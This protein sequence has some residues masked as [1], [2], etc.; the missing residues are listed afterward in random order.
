MNG[1]ALLPMIWK[2][3]TRQQ[4]DLPADILTHAPELFSILDHL[5]EHVVYLDCDLRV[6][7]AVLP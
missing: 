1:T 2:R 3:L 5:R 4:H 7:W 6:R